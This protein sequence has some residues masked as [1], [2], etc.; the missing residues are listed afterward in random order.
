MIANRYGVLHRTGR[1]FDRLY[2]KRHPKQRHDDGDDRRLKILPPNRLGRTGWLRFRLRRRTVTI[3]TEDPR[4]SRRLRSCLRL[5]YVGRKWPAGR[6]A[7]Y[8]VIL[9][10]LDAAV[11]FP[12]SLSV[13]S[14]HQ[15]KGLFG[16]S[17]L[18]RFLRATLRSHATIVPAYLDMES[19]TMWRTN[20][21]HYRI[22]WRRSPFR[23]QF[24]LQHCLV[25]GLCRG[26]WRNFLK[27]LTQRL[28]NKSGCR[29]QSAINKNRT[30]ER[31][32]NIGQ[33]RILA[34]AAAHLLA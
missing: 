32:Q 30:S 3:A 18:G 11:K 22:L 6:I 34:T 24:L 7:H 13:V 19:A 26:T 28:L 1:N 14:S 9:D 5:G 10:T 23:L 17:S 31:L 2:Y 27:F 8:Q 29:R 21:L 12:R 15:C 33:Q 4:K 20:R 16:G 25:V